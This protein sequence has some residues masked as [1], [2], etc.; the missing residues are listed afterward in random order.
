MADYKRINGFV[1][2]GGRSTR[3][4]QDKA[5]MCLGK[6]P[7]VL[8]AAEILTPFVDELTLLAPP[9]RYGN[10]GLPVVADIW[11]EQGPLAALC[12]GMICSR[13]EWNIFLACDLPLVSPK[14]LELLIRRVHAT[15]SDAIVPRNEYG[16]QPLSA[17]YR[18]SC[19]TVFA[20]AIREGRRGIVGILDE[21]AMEMVS[22]DEMMNAGLSELELFNANTP[23]EWARL[24]HLLEGAR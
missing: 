11:P 19:R 18:L 9:G 10:L 8:R 16:W 13:A 7:L 20:R 2:A 24:A 5:L 22:R 12:T 21:I 4:G 23:D 6:K 1:Q 14:F 3:M 15:R 17:A